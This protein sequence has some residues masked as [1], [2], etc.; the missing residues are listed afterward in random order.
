MRTS[1]PPSD[2]V[3]ELIKENTADTNGKPSATKQEQ[4]TS[5]DN[6]D[7]DADKPADH[8]D[9]SE[10]LKDGQEGG[11]GGKGQSREDDGDERDAAKA[12][13]EAAAVGAA[14]EEEITAVEDASGGESSV[15]KGGTKES[16]D[17]EGGNDVG[18]TENGDARADERG[19]AGSASGET[20]SAE[21]DEP[22]RMADERWQPASSAAADASSSGTTGTTGK[23]TSR[24][25]LRRNLHTIAA[26]KDK[27]V[28]QK[29]LDAVFHAVP[30]P[31]IHA[32]A[33]THTHVHA[34]PLPP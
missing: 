30:H 6:I 12:N 2:G 29:W 18:P 24:T 13:G 25:D 4:D 31:C 20:A 22:D 3:V 11:E 10:E 26:A 16:I 32:C 5:T 17:G 7:A 34:S 21:A 8:D 15:S 14:A 1:L 27:R 33:R 28:C 19:E 23:A 9:K